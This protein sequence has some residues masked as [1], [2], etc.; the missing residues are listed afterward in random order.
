[1]SRLVEFAPWQR[2]LGVDRVDARAD[3]DFHAPNFQHPDNPEGRSLI[4]QVT[5]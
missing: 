1:M 2:P 5:I 3:A 4:K